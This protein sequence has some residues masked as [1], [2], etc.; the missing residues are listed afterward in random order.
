MF[1]SL[2]AILVAMLLL[3]DLHVMER[4]TDNIM[5]NFGLGNKSTAQGSIISI[6]PVRPLGTIGPASY[7]L[8][9]RFSA[10]E[11]YRIANS[12]V[13]RRSNIPGW[14]I[15]PETQNN[16]HLTVGETLSLSEPFPVVVEYVS[17]RPRA[18]R[19]VGTR[20]SIGIIG[21]ILMVILFSPIIIA[22]IF[23]GPS[24]LRNPK[25][26]LRQGVFTT[27]YI[28]WRRS[29]SVSLSR[30]T[31]TLN[32]APNYVV[33][34]M[35]QFGE[36]WEAPILAPKEELCGELLPF[37]ASIDG[38]IGFLYLPDVGAVIVPDS[39]Q[40]YTLKHAKNFKPTVTA[41]HKPVYCNPIE[42][43]QRDA[44]GKSQASSKDQLNF[45]D[46]E[47]IVTNDEA[48]DTD[49]EVV[50][51]DHEAT[52][53]EQIENMSQEEITTKLKEMAERRNGGK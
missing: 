14:G 43:R 1:Y 18:A 10:P 37:L 17:G 29:S 9:T 8:R 24:D 7:Y 51:I 42:K 47:F 48:V 23:K 20:L 32:L 25:R 26:L 33:S 53:W 28:Y 44:N 50:D 36:E 40:G 3:G 19:A 22:V 46:D 6:T 39:W 45:L 21:I 31:E 2:I 41:G 15:I 13:W 11:G 5:L 4:I 12:Y 35:D 16:P 38:P 49:D 27:G 52:S 34:F 30:L